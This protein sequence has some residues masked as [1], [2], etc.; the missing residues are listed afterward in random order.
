[1][2]KLL[3][4]IFAGLS[5]ALFS[6]DKSMSF[7]ASSSTRQEQ[8]SS[9]KRASND[10]PT[11]SGSQRRRTHGLAPLLIIEEAVPTKLNTIEELLRTMGRHG[12][13]HDMKFL[14]LKKYIEGAENSLFE[15]NKII[16]DINNRMER[17]ANNRLSALKKEIEAT[18]STDVQFDIPEKSKLVLEQHPHKSPVEQLNAL[19]RISPSIFECTGYNAELQRLEKEIRTGLSSI[20]Q[21]NRELITTTLKEIQ[22]D[23]PE[24]KLITLRKLHREYIV[25]RRTIRSPVTFSPELTETRILTFDYDPLGTIPDELDAHTETKAKELE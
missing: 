12:I 7:M 14:E 6:A 15:A 25:Q 16:N 18:S 24:K 21:N 17:A 10:E 19:Q 8:A 5:T 2:K 3:L 23:S 4:I 11:D 22:D 1:M 20:P 9:S 13:K